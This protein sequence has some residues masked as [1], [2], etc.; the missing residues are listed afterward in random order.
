MRGERARRA[1]D[2]CARGGGDIFFPWVCGIAQEEM[3]AKLEEMHVPGVD[4]PARMDG[5]RRRRVG[6]GEFDRMT[7]EY[8]RAVAR[9]SGVELPG[10]EEMGRGGGGSWTEGGAQRIIFVVVVIVFVFRMAAMIFN[11]PAVVP[12]TGASEPTGVI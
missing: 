2:L 6:S 9:E 8:A 10:S 3:L 5:G 11:S 7:E 4:V 1:G 12:R